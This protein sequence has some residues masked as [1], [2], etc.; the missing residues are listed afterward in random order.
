M[1]DAISPEQY[2][3][4]VFDMVNHGEHFDS[5]DEASHV[6][7]LH[8]DLMKHEQ[9]Q[10]HPRGPLVWFAY[11]EIL[12]DIDSQVEYWKLRVGYPEYLWVAKV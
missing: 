8:L 5:L 7:G 2:L 3:E 10:G 12:K 11:N 4:V 9:A 1:N 6:M